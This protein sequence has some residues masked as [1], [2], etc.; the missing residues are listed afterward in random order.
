MHL[1]PALDEKMTNAP[2]P[3]GFKQRGQS[4]PP[5][6]AGFGKN[7]FGPRLF[8]FNRSR[9]VTTRES[10]DDCSNAPIRR[11]RARLFRRP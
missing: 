4:N 10:D 11:Q 2:V 7:N 5:T 1:A 9:R 3:K 8:Q 6:G